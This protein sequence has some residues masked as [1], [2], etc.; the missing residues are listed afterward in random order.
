[1]MDRPVLYLD[2]DDTLLDWS[3][4][5]PKAVP[6][7]RDF[8]LWASDRFEIRWLT[9]WC[10]N[11]RMKAELLKDLRKMLRLKPPVLDAVHGLDWSEGDCKLN[12]IA[13][14]EHLVLGR[15]FFWV[16]DE[17]GVGERELRM[18]DEHGLRESYHHCNVSRDSDALA[19]V[20]NELRRQGSAAAARA[21]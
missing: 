12:G 15:P 1:M 7:A 21:A 20:W 8:V 14:V 18:L 2:L 4:G 6:L 16:E 11:G 10:R 3:S 17:T 13:W 19:R 5:G 9:R